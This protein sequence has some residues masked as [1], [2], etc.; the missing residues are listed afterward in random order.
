MTLTESK[1]YNK[2]WYSNG[3]WNNK[4]LKCNKTRTYSNKWNS[5]VGTKKSCITCCNRKLRVSLNTNIIEKL[6]MNNKIWC[7]N[8]KWNNKC[9][10][11]NKTRTYITKRNA[12][13][14]VDKICISCSKLGHKISEETR[15]KMSNARI[16]TKLSN[17]T[18]EK[19]S[20]QK[21]GVKN[22]RFGKAP[23]EKHR[24]NMRIAAI[25]RL[26]K[27]GIMIAFNSSACRFIDE[28]GVKYGYNFQHAMNG[29]EVNL[30]GF[31]VDGYDKNKN[32][33]F[34]YDEPAHHYK[35][36]KEKD[37]NKQ[38]LIIEKIRPT[39]FIRYD[40]KNNRLY[41]VITGLDI[42]K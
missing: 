10:R 4:C 28:F 14:G 20:I 21:I 37:I 18:K 15:H 31:L 5:Y 27:Q 1:N 40:Q 6:V 9:L 2:I 29:G 32:V 42:V 16:G 35:R 12:F 19:L 23:S 33:I 13:I 41:D 8:R 26:K 7:F 11:C 39:M 25:N 24:E 22:P 34:E 38:T 36:I 17:Q 3:K 30:Y